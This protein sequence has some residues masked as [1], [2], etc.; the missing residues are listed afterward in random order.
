MFTRFTLSRLRRL[1][2]LPVLLLPLYQA[3]AAPVDLKTLSWTDVEAQAR[4]EGQLTWFNWYY[5]DRLRDEVKAFERQYGIRVT[6]PDGEAAA[7]INKLLAEQYRERG[8][9]DVISVGGSQFGLLNGPK[10]FWGPLR[11][12]LPDGDKLTYQIEG[13]D[14]QGYAVAFWGNQTVIAYHSARIN[15]RDLPR[16]LPQFEQFLQKN[17][18]EFTFNVENGGSGPAFIESI[19]RTLVTDVNYRDGHVSPET[20][21]RLAPS[22]RWFNRYKSSLVISASNADSLTRLN[23]GEFKL[24]ASWE[25]LVLSQQHNG[26]LSQDIKFYLPEFGMPGG[27]NVVGIPANARHKAAALLFIHWL[28]LPDTQR[29]FHAQFGTAPLLPS[30]TDDATEGVLDRSHSFAWAAKPLGD[31]IKKQFIQNVMLK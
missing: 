5:Q 23:A 3:Q 6:I 13:V 26:D 16:T 9:I 17:P 31:E 27:G 11:S 1:V 14:T 19:T 12:R 2:A 28:T 24:A 7:S 25:D 18:G 15:E 21:Q 30:G 22:W 10:L 29:R 20:V 8:D 4:Q